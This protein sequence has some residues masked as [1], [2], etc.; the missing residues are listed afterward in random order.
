MTVLGDDNEGEYIDV[1]VFNG[2]L[3]LQIQNKK[4]HRSLNFYIKF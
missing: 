2:F 4:G 3:S 1:G